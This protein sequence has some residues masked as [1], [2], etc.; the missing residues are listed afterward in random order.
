MERRGS[1]SSLCECC[2]EYIL[3][4]NF[5]DLLQQKNTSPEFD[6]KA[7]YPGKIKSGCGT[8]HSHARRL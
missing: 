2:F 6:K 3:G 7:D 1:T 4:S 5:E 8:N